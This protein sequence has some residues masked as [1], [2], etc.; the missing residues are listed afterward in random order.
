M[1]ILGFSILGNPKMVFIYILGY[2][3]PL[4]GA[5][6]W[7]GWGAYRG[8]WV[9]YYQI[10]CVLSILGFSIARSSK[11]IFIF[12]F[13]VTKPPPPQGR[14]WGRCGVVWTTLWP[15]FSP[16]IYMMWDTQRGLKT[17][18]L[19]FFVK[20]LPHPGHFCWFFAKIFFFQKIDLYPFNFELSC[21]H[22]FLTE[23]DPPYHFGKGRS[24][25]RC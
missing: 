1:S 25:L 17:E 21:S 10:S 18:I 24:I 5:L 13:R 9:L 19:N 3:N 2:P 12:H 7:G 20:Y 16:G 22:Q 15:I 14:P 6:R 8:C 4:K 23:N 11:S